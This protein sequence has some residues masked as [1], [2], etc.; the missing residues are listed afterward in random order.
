MVKRNLDV[1]IARQKVLVLILDAFCAA[2]DILE[3]LENLFGLDVGKIGIYNLAI[4][5]YA[6]KY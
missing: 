5:A 2:F 4:F 3:R 1:G 6:R